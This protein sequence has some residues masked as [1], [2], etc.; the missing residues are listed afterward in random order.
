MSCTNPLYALDLGIKEN[1]KHAI[2]LLPRRVDLSSQHQIEYRYGKGSVIP[3]PCGKCLNCKLAHARQ[4]AVRCSLEAS[5]HDDNC[6]ITLTYA[7]EY[8]PPLAKLRKKD[9]QLFFQRLQMK[10]PGARYF[11]C[12]EYG[13][14]NKRPHYHA[15]IFG[16]YLQE[17]DLKELWPYGLVDIDELNF[18]TAQ[19][20]ARY[21][22]KK[23][24]SKDDEFLLMSLKPGIG[25]AW[26]EKHPDIF[27]YDQI[28]GSFG[29][30]PVPRYF[31]KLAA[32]SD[33]DLT[34]LKESRINSSCEHQLYEMLLH[35]MQHVEQLYDYKA[36]IAKNKHEHMKRRQGL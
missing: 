36:D 3:L 8:L 32:L 18:F 23:S 24:G 2:K 16:Y 21:T 9:L 1:G 28:I 5:L 4:W 14:Q 26:V 17:K 35:Q 19:Y 7:D 27:K 10:Y 34:A 30:A 22:V 15:L 33:I 11:A 29:C 6:F 25:A 13:D 12:G 31:E 20:V